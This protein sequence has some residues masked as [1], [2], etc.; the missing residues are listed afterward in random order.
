MMMEN[1]RNMCSNEHEESVQQDRQGC[2]F[3][4]V[5]EEESLEFHI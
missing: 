4:R 1:Y 5:V 2:V 3:D